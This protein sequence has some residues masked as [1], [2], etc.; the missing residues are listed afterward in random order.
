MWKK[1]EIRYWAYVTE[2]IP[3][4][5][6]VGDNF[7]AENCSKKNIKNRRDIYIIWFR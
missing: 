5:M 1:G 4:K 2:V 7:S 3:K 6:G